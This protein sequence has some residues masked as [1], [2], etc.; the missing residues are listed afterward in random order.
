MMELGR[1]WSLI[2]LPVAFGVF[3]SSGIIGPFQLLP[4]SPVILM[5]DF[6]LSL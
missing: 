2:L 5:Q 6:G 3:T 4:P 1:K